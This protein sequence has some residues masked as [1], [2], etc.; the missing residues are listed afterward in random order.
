MTQLRRLATALI[1]LACILGSDA[2]YAGCIRVCGMTRCGNICTPTPRVQHPTS[3]PTTVS[4]PS[5]HV[6]S[7]QPQNLQSDQPKQTYSPPPVA[8]AIAPPKAA[9]AGGETF[10]SRPTVKLPPPLPPQG[11]S[12]F[13]QTPPHPQMETPGRVTLAPIKLSE[14]RYATQSSQS[15]PVAIL[16]GGR[17]QQQCATCVIGKD[18]V[19]TQTNT[20]CPQGNCTFKF[21]GGANCGPGGPSCWQLVSGSSSSGQ[22]SANPS[23]S[24]PISTTNAA[25]TLRPYVPSTGPSWSRPDTFSD[26]S[27]N[28]LHSANKNVWNATPSARA[29][30][31]TPKQSG[32]TGSAASNEV[33]GSGGSDPA[34][35]PLNSGDLAA[36]SYATEQNIWESTQ[37]AITDYQDQY[38][39]DVKRA[40]YTFEKL[41]WDR[42]R[43]N[44]YNSSFEQ[45]L[46]Y[47]IVSGTTNAAIDTYVPKTGD[48]LED[49]MNSA[50]HILNR[51]PSLNWTFRG[52]LKRITQIEF[53]LTGVFKDNL[54]YISEKMQQFTA[55]MP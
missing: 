43:K 6:T 21:L 20:A 30:G 48:P 8:R 23:G 14:S 38:S 15:A 35:G 39:D 10:W 3:R 5:S 37:T 44:D 42:L 29:P 55:G 25:T 13:G 27:Q 16:T 54:D 31:V 41:E 2:A 32:S 4:R 12:V 36:G 7:R 52:A 53:G 1:Y 22:A 28:S 19:L 11:R 51:M 24:G 9:V 34:T 26:D 17:G 46:G 50:A 18:Y 45:N 47:A 49:T 33:A 40:V